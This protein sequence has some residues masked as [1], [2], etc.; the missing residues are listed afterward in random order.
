MS[1][2]MNGKR[3]RYVFYLRESVAAEAAVIAV[4]DDLKDL[5]EL[6]GALRRAVVTAFSASTA[7][8][9]QPTQQ[10]NV[11]A[12]LQAAGGWQGKP[13]PKPGSK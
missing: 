9:P 7:D 5:N 8:A 10:K 6:S 3:Q 11:G 2:R 1:K 4:L 13:V 12:L